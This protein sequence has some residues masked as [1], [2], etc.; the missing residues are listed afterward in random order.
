MVLVKD[1][2][3]AADPNSDA[4]VPFDGPIAQLLQADMTGTAKT[5]GK[6]LI[7]VLKNAVAEVVE[8]VAA[9]AEEM[10]TFSSFTSRCRTPMACNLRNA[11]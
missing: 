5:V 9:S 3:K 4:V 8:G 2:K 7:S 1:V 11:S 10:R 6:T